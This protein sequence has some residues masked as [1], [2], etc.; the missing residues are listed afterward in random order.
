MSLNYSE[1]TSLNKKNYRKADNGDIMMTVVRDISIDFPSRIY[2]GSGCMDKMIADVQSLGL[3][4]V[5]VVSIKPLLDKLQTLIS[6]LEGVGTA[7]LLNTSIEQEPTFL[8]MDQLI[9]AYANKGIEGVIGVGG[10]SVLDIAKLAAVQLAGN[11]KLAEI[12]GKNRIQGRDI[13]LICVPTTSGT[14]S[15]ASPNAILIDPADHQKK[16][17]I[18]PFLMPDLVCIDPTLTYS[19]PPAV[20]AAT[21]LDA[22]THCLEAY[23]NKFA[24]PFID[25]Y[26][27]QGVKLIAANL[28]RAVEMG[29]DAVARA[30]VALG[31]L[32]GG[33]CLGPVNTAAVHALAYPLGT[34]FHIAHGLSNA[35]LLPHVMAFNI[36]AAVARYADIALAIGCEKSADDIKTA[37]AGVEKVKQLI[38][39]CKLPARLRDLAIPA[40][41]IPQMA[42]DA[43]KISRLLVNNPREI[44]IQDAI[45]I[46][47]Q[48]F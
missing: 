43:M 6:E 13:K 20:T 18:S 45:S 34:T 16:G 40:D 1:H 38:K 22:L 10:G 11:Q 48:A 21:G 8:D 24:H 4:K 14:G 19:V 36:P 17:I 28:I 3:K 31:S 26:A 47:Q 27:L 23:T 5:L 42:E 46:Y 15:E 41:S 9:Q 30:E 7:V 2:F 37:F 25:T 44:T 12:V 35:L 39:A 32:F 29:D 33:F